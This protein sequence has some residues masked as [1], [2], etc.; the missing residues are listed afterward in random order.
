MLSRAPKTLLSNLNK[1]SA[2]RSFSVLGSNTKMQVIDHTYDAIV[3]GAGGAGLR[4]RVYK[5]NQI[6][7]LLLVFQ[8]L[9][10]KLLASRNF[11]QL[12]PTLLLHK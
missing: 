5:V 11:S 9:D 3:V 6:I 10:S 7:R 2:N 1:Q 4:V 12:D 8:R